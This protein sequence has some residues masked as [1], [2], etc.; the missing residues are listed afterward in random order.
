MT[1]EEYESLYAEALHTIRRKIVGN[2][3]TTNDG[4]R[5][6]HIDGKPHSDR[7]VFVKA[8]EVKTAELIMARR[9]SPS[10]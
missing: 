7:D 1:H 5:C 8:W 4:V 6:V 3:E 9:P 2:F 10:R